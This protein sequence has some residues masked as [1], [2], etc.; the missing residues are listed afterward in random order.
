MSSSQIYG[1]KGD[2][3]SA[4][5]VQKYTQ[6]PWDVFQHDL[7]TAASA[8][9]QPPS[10]GTAP[11]GGWELRDGNMAAAE[12]ADDVFDEADELNLTSPR[13]NF[14]TGGEST[15]RTV[16]MPS[17]VTMPTSHIA[18]PQAPFA[19]HSSTGVD[20]LSRSGSSSDV[21][22]MRSRGDRI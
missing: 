17:A 1:P 16:N 18:P 2:P 13:R 5:G 10:G 14:S 7:Q 6:V 12:A 20:P 9:Q 22:E 15:M 19:A 3:H 8:Q 11:R 4:P 21:I